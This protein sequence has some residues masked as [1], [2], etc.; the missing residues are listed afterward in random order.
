[1]NNHPDH[2]DMIDTRAF[3]KGNKR[4]TM[5]KLVIV[6][7]IALTIMGLHC[8]ALHKRI[9]YLEEEVASVQADFIRFIR[10]NTASLVKAAEEGVR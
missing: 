7:T 5:K 9:A 8:Y 2:C 6:L 3:T 1:M 10:E 4:Y